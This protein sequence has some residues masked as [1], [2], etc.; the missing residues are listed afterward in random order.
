MTAR[1]S[2]N[3][4]YSIGPLVKTKLSAILGA[5][6]N[7]IATFHEGFGVALATQSPFLVVFSQLSARLYKRWICYE[8]AGTVCRANSKSKH[9]E[10]ALVLASNTCAF[11]RTLND[12]VA[13]FPDLLQALA[14]HICSV[15]SGPHLL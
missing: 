4:E 10:P 8:R 15:S 9:E 5:R 11:A 7:I 1:P 3:G 13:R 6:S 2:P 14:A 12:G